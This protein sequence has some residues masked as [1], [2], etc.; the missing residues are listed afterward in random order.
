[1]AR[2]ELQAMTPGEVTAADVRGIIEAA[3]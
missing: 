1:M 3:W 2:G